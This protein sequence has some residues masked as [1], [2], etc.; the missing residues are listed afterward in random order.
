MKKTIGSGQSPSD[1]E[2]DPSWRDDSASPWF[3]IARNR[4]SLINPFKARALGSSPSR[5]TKLIKYFSLLLSLS[6]KQVA[7]LMA[8][9]WSANRK[10]VGKK[11]LRL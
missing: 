5:L 9:G 11:D 3:S 10:I 7:D 8:P 6:I 4:N 2:K 1:D